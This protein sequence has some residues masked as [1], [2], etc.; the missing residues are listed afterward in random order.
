M[1]ANIYV[2]AL[3]CST[4][5]ACSSS[6]IGN[7]DPY[8][9]QHESYSLGSSF[10]VKLRIPNRYLET[11]VEYQGENV[12]DPSTIRKVPATIETPISS[13]TIALNMDNLKPIESQEDRAA[14]IHSMD[15]M[16]GRDKWMS[17][18]ATSVDLH[19][20]NPQ[21]LIRRTLDN[22]HSDDQGY[23]EDS[24]FFV[25][26]G[27]HHE[28]SK[29]SFWDITSKNQPYSDIFYS[30]SSLN[31]LIT[32]GYIRQIVKPYATFQR[33]HQY[34]YIPDMN[35]NVELYYPIR[36]INRWREFQVKA[37]DIL[38]LLVVK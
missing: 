20:A 32:C 19:S 34:F 29:S 27:L 18:E 16:F 38:H 26:K 7:P 28:V 14:Y 10:G 2:V 3:M 5:A 13:F 15:A 30:E 36:E 37:D 22:I 24:L 1:K 33:C 4:I 35:V 21:T 12:F 8:L 23:K 31:T 11:P 25:V 17:I 6:Q 9:A